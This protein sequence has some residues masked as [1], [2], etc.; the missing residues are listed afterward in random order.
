MLSTICRVEENTRNSEIAAKLKLPDG[1]VTASTL[2]F[3][4][5]TR[6]LVVATLGLLVVA[7]SLGTT[8][9]DLAALNPW[10]AAEQGGRGE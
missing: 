8:G 3:E 7:L 2:C 1:R 5:M 4:K 9:A 6:P 10:E